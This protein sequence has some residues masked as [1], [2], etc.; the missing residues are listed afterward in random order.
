MLSP[1]GKDSD[2][3]CGEPAAAGALP[4]VAAGASPGLSPSASADVADDADDYREAN[5]AQERQTVLLRLRG[6]PYGAQERD[7]AKFFDNCAVVAA[8]V[9]RRAGPF[10][11]PSFETE[12]KNAKVLEGVLFRSLARPLTSSP[13][14]SFTLLPG[15]PTGEGYAEF[16]T[17][18]EASRA[19]REK[20]HGSLGSRYVELFAE[21]GADPERDPASAGRPLPGGLGNPVLRLRG[22]PFTATAPDVVDFLIGRVGR[23]E[24]VEKKKKTKKS[25]DGEEETQSSSSPSTQQQQ[26]RRAWSVLPG[27][28]PTNP[29]AMPRRGASGVVF[30][31]SPDGRPSG[32]AYVEFESPQAASAALCVDGTAL[33]TRYVS[34]D[35]CFIILDFF[36]FHFLNLFFFF[37]HRR[38]FKSKTT[39]HR[40][41]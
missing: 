3:D 24:G 28:P 2:K 8:Y 1:E 40:H 37:S 23:E 5:S 12:K 41:H 25:D 19:L 4:D 7:I 9:C 33:G 38:F 32:E 14:L 22:L 39:N 13:S 16:S 36:S 11:F 26:Q 34:F 10:F 29:E 27:P 35:F 6:L 15:R 18:A 31:S 21:Q 17:A 30:T 20:Q